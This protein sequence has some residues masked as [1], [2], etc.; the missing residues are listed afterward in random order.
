MA[1]LATCC[2]VDVSK[3]DD[4]PKPV[5][6]GWSS[7]AIQ[8]KSF[9]RL[10]PVPTVTTPMFLVSLLGGDSEVCRLFPRSHF[11]L[12]ADVSGKILILVLD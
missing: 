7:A 11:A 8:T 3:K 6:R 9:A 12:A 10:Q 5:D 1:T 4:C 2:T